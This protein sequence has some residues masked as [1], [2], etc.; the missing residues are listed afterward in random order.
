MHRN[1]AA[2]LYGGVALSNGLYT[3]YI[4][5]ITLITAKLKNTKFVEHCP[6]KLLRETALFLIWEKNKQN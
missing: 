5:A 4:N 3:G 6:P 2:I 1:V